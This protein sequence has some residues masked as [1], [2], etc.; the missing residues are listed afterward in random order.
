MMRS[1]FAALLVAAASSAA[2]AGLHYSGEQF[3]DLPSQWRGYLL[4]HRSL[5]ML[6]RPRLP[7]QSSSPLY[8]R[9]QAD[10]DRLE[11]LQRRQRLTADD[12]ADLG[13]LYIR[14]GQ[15]ERA[16]E[17]LRDYVRQAP[18]HFRVAANLGTACQLTGDF[19]Q[20][21]AALELAVRMAP[22]KYRKAEELHLKLVRMRR[23]EPKNTQSLDDLF[24]GLEKPPGD[25]VS[26]VQT[27]GLWLPTDGRLLW[28]IGEVA[29]ATGD[30]GTAAAV[31]EGCVTDFGMDNRLLR[32]HRKE[33][34]EQT[35]TAAK[36]P[37]ADRSAV[38]ATH[39]GHDATGIRFRSV[40]PLV[41]KPEALKLPPITP[42]GVNSLPW[43]VLA[44]T[45][46]A[47]P[48]RPQYIE[49]LRQLDGKRV[50][51]HGYMQ[52]IGDG[53][54]QSAV[55]LIEFPVGCWFCEVPEPTGIVLV[56]SP[57]D[58]PIRLTRELVRVEGRLKL[59]FNDPEDFLYTIKD[60][61]VG[62]PE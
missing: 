23:G 3:A 59:N 5:R 31:L 40:R 58:K 9:Y 18:E 46:L 34:R 39:Q 16:V 1:F 15:S 24:G 2:H 20:A 44:E 13:A 12:A 4:D 10:R 54:E 11:K 56:E 57:E 33:Y 29:H 52:P 7:N 22:A 25:A 62:S 53:L 35:D 42:N 38:T 14:L 21:I 45:T 6:A 19:D 37:A 27:L 32:E 47:K 51:T 28:Q 43:T 49:H 41:R 17:L 61:K 50:V 8:D 60:A 48:F 55:L 36:A 30:I 26:L